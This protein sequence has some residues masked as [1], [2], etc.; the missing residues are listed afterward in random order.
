MAPATLLLCATVLLAAACHGAPHASTPGGVPRRVI[1][2]TNIRARQAPKLT[3]MGPYPKAG[4][5]SLALDYW[6][7]LADPT[8]VVDYP[9]T[10]AIG[11]YPSTLDIL[12]SP[13]TSDYPLSLSRAVG[14]PYHGVSSAIVDSYPYSW[15]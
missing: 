14:L 4:A 5:R 2:T 10:V 1:D 13:W 11:S 6:H 9:S 3:K 15:Y 12:H 7:H 8:Y